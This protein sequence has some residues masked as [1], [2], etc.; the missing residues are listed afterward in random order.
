MSERW[1]DHHNAQYNVVD[2]IG[3]LTLVGKHYIEDPCRECIGKH[4]Q[5]I[6]ALAREARGLNDALQMREFLDAAEALAVKHLSIIMECAVKENGHCDIHGKGDMQKLFE[7]T[8]V[9][10][11]ELN[12]KVFGFAADLMYDSDHAGAGHGHEHAHEAEESDHIRM[13]D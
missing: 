4:L 2:I 6:L 10:R 8:R 12:M 1:L 3:N 13:H 5:E 7:E 9:L 11:R